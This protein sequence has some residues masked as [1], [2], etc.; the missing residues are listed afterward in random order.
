MAFFSD[1]NFIVHRNIQLSSYVSFCS[2]QLVA[3]LV[4]ISN[5]FAFLGLSDT[6]ISFPSQMCIM[7]TICKIPKYPNNYSSEKG[8]NIQWEFFLVESGE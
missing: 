7:T 8:Q 1:L 2:M 6:T 4:D 3:F 5:F